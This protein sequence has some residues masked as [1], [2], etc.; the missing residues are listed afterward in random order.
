MAAQTNKEE[1]QPAP[2]R[3]PSSLSLF[4]A[5]ALMMACFALMRGYMH[6]DEHHHVMSA[7]HGEK[8]RM[9][10]EFMS[11]SAALWMLLLGEMPATHL[12]HCSPHYCFQPRGGV[13]ETLSKLQ[14]FEEKMVNAIEEKIHGFSEKISA[15]H[16]NPIMDA[17]HTKAQKSGAE[18]GEAGGDRMHCS[19]LDAQCSSTQRSFVEVVV[20]RIIAADNTEDDPI[21]PRV[22][23]E[24]AHGE[25]PREEGE[26]EEDE[27]DEEDEEEDGTENE[28]EA[29]MK[30]DELESMLE[31]ALK[32]RLFVLDG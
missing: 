31:A 8:E 24:A 3:L 27:D 20:T 26:E 1:A 12:G 6:A 13:S 2:R 19:A 9:R 29:N 16:E 11:V 14:R 10:E 17:P 21:S 18:K 23:R 4:G 7:R 28:V 30:A 22:P 25:S 15:A 32:V 5:A